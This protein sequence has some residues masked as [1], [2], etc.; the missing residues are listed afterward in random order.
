VEAGQLVLE[1]PGAGARAADRAVRGRALRRGVQATGEG[2]EIGR[3][4]VWEPGRRVAYT[5]R[6]AD[7]PPGQEMEI[8]VRFAPAVAATLVTIDVRGWSG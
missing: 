4:T 7:W 6:Q 2:F 5:W 1:R 8:E 3:V